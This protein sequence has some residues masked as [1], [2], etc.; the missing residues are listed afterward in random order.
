MAMELNLPNIWQFTSAFS[1]FIIG[2]Y[3][4]LASLFNQDIK[5]FIYL[6]LLLFVTIATYLMMTLIN[7]K[8]DENNPVSEICNLFK[9]PL[10]GNYKNPS[11]TTTILAFTIAYLLLPMHYSKQTNYVVITTLFSFLILDGLTKIKN[12]CTSGTGVVFGAL[13]GFTLGWLM[14][15]LFYSTDSTNFLFF[16]EVLSNRAICSMPAK[17]LF[18]CKVFKDGIPIGEI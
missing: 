17:T 8:I 3:L 18:K 1:P 9:I 5:G 13:Y 2:S 7:E 11:Y 4:V 15:M 10:V 6:L 14:V 16:S 12:G